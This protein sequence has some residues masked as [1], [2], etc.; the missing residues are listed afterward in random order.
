MSKVSLEVPFTIVACECGQD[1]AAG[2][3]CPNC[4]SVKVYD[5]P[6][7]DRRARII[8]AVRPLFDEPT[9]SREPITPHEVFGTLGGWADP[10]IS[11]CSEIMGGSEQEAI[12]RIGGEAGSYREIADRIG[13]TVRKHREAKAWSVID[14][15]MASLRGVI[16]EYLAA[17]STADPGACA[18]HG[19]AAQR[20]LDAAGA[21]A[22]SLGR[23]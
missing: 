2:A 4:G 7:V 17:L 1:R 18:Q 20:S 10:F 19:A 15:V 11:A 21:I 8:A 9:G 13:A 3:R 16:D 14:G 12:A 5:D 6:L 22:G 23:A